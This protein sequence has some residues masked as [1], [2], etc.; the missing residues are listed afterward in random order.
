VIRS[1]LVAALALAAAACHPARAR[2]DDP[3]F[4]KLTGRV[5]DEAGL[6]TPAQEAS[7][8]ARSEAVERS[9]GAQYVI[10]TLRSLQGRPIEDY[11]VRLGRHW[12]VGRKYPNDGLLL[13]VAP[14][15]RKVRIEVGYGLEKRVTD[16]FAAKVIR[17]D[18]LPRFR[19]GRFA[20]G[21]AAGSE[22]LARRLVS[23]ESERQIA[24]EDHVST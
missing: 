14:S 2:S 1:V 6:L 11:G 23:R 12:G 24:I 5:V 9:T 18:I 17:D 8:A 21:I 10:V 15:E 7:L 19:Q 16:P 13:I 3:I 20:E 4:P 22:D